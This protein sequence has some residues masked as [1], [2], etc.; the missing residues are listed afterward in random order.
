MKPMQIDFAPGSLARALS[1]IDAITWVAAGIGLGACLF[2]G[3]DSV[4]LMQQHTDDRAAL[5]RAIAQQ[6]LRLAQIVVAPKK[7][8]P[9]AEINAVNTAI[10]QLNLPWR[11]LL[12][13]VE[14]ATPADIALLSLEPD[15]AKHSLKGS[16]EARDSAGMI[17]Y[18]ESL[19]Q[20]NFFGEVVLTRHETNETDTRKPLRFQFE[21][22]W[23]G[24]AP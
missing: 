21:A 9:A 12:D 24:R 3:F 11:D 14:R 18:I 8:V 23:Q 5:Q 10:S 22:Y 16:A 20:Q 13:A 15:A 2:F 4:R 17:A 6:Q 19:Q 1:R 7:S